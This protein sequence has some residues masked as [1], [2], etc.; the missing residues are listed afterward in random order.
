ME[1]N[2]KPGSERAFLEQLGLRVRRSRAD[3]QMTRRAL[4]DASGVSQRYLAQLEAG[5]GNISVLLIRRVAGALGVPLTALLAD[6]AAASAR[7]R[8]IALVGL[9]GAGK[10]TLGAALAERME[11]PFRELDA[12]IERDLGASL[13]SIFTMYGQ[14]AY[15]NAERRALQRVTDELEACV[16]ATGGSIVVEPRTHELLRQRC[17]TVWLKAT[18]Q[19]HM[20]RVIA[21]GDLRPMQGREHA[22]AELRALLAQRER[23]Y[24]MAD[25]AVETSGRTLAETLEALAAA[26]G[27]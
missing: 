5:E 27:A 4:A 6:D 1:G 10:S 19:E 18:P 14:E 24:A 22:M 15:R 2:D 3:A 21:Q 11:V 16:I 17:L 26:V 9:R 8:H 23:L 20:D 12:E 7:R 13:A 25:L